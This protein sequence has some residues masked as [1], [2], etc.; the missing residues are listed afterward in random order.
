M[1]G[2]CGYSEEGDNGAIVDFRT[3]WSKENTLDL[4]ENSAA[5]W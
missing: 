5:R 2:S 1:T 4:S 3:K